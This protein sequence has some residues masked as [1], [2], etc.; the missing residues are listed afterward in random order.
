MTELIRQF[1]N[2]HTTILN[3]LNKVKKENLSIEERKMYLLTAKSVLKHHLEKEDS[4]LYPSLK[5]IE[6]D[7]ILK[8]VNEFMIG[9][10]RIG[11]IIQNFFEIEESK[12][13]KIHLDPNFA[14]IVKLLEV[15]IDKE[16]KGLYPLHNE[17]LI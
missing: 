16:E 9:L 1:T 13:A 12:I 2:D 4:D 10:E 7:S 14:K 8:T 6:N 5:K 3:L 17:S 11:S 15:R